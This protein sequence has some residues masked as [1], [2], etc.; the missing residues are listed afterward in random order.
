MDYGTAINDRDDI[1]GWGNGTDG[2]MSILEYTNGVLVDLVPLYA[3]DEALQRK[4][5]VDNPHRLYGFGS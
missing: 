5:L 2:S 3:P 1:V 4:I